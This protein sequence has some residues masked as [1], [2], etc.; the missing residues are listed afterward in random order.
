MAGWTPFDAKSVRF[1]A[2]VQ[3]VYMCLWSFLLKFIF[4]LKVCVRGEI[5]F[6]EGSAT[7]F[8]KLC[9]KTTESYDGSLWSF[10]YFTVDVCYWTVP[11]RLTSGWLYVWEETGSVPSRTLSLDEAAAKGGWSLSPPFV[12]GAVESWRAVGLQP[13]ATDGGISSSS[14][15]L[16]IF[17]DANIDCKVWDRQ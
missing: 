3:G 11:E 4:S 2:L 9:N 1:L 13:M 7:V 15:G 17:T 8:Y 16:P 12:I 10:A 5:H 14:I 6:N